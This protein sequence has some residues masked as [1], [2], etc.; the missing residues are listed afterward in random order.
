MWHTLVFFSA[1]KKTSPLH[2]TVVGLSALPCFLV[3][4]T[5]AIVL[6][7][8]HL[9]KWKG[10]KG[11]PSPI[12]IY[13]NFYHVAWKLLLIIWKEGGSLGELHFWAL[14]LEYFTFDH[15]N[16]FWYG[17]QLAH[18]VTLIGVCVI[19]ILFFWGGWRCAPKALIIKT[20]NY[21]GSQNSYWILNIYFLKIKLNP[22]WKFERNW[23]VPLILLQ[24][25]QWTWFIL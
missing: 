20:W 24:R 6:M 19:S 7:P 3:P 1:F 12:L 10:L 8:R 18:E 2:K 23:D 9:K 5:W 11:Y 4:I 22:N 25:S 14:P 21:G 13:V 15:Q 16:I 17:L